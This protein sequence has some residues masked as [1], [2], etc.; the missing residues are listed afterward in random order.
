MTDLPENMGASAEPI[1]LAGAE[2]PEPPSRLGPSGGIPSAEAVVVSTFQYERLK[3]EL[4]NPVP[5]SGAARFCGLPIHESP[6]MPE[7][8][9]GVVE[10]PQGP[11]DLRPAWKRFKL[12]RLPSDSDGNP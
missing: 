7:G 4:A 12:F 1:G 6:S 11:T 9:F 10:P 8:F 3:A 5:P 2:A